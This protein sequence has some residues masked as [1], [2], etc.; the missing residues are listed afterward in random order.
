VVTSG[1]VAAYGSGGGRSF[2]FANI[3][4]RPAGSP[5]LSLYQNLSLYTIPTTAPW[6]GT[7][8]AVFGKTERT[9]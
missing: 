7:A 2:S 9:V 1:T 5:D 8:K 6:A 3:R 4:Q